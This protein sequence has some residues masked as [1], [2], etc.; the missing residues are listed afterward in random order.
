VGTES[1]YQIGERVSTVDGFPGEII[2]VVPGPVNGTESYHVLLD[3]NLGGGEYTPSQIKPITAQRSA[4]LQEFDTLGTA[5]VD[6]P[7]LGDILVKKPNP[8]KNIKMGSKLACLNCGCDDPTDDHGNPNN[9]TIDS[10]PSCGHRFNKK[11]SSIIALAE[12]RAEQLEQN[13]DQINRHQRPRAGAVC[14]HCKFWSANAIAGSICPLCGSIMQDDNDQ[15]DKDNVSKQVHDSSDF[16]EADDQDDDE[17]NDSLDFGNPSDSSDSDSGDSGGDSGTTASL[18][19]SLEYYTSSVNSPFGEVLVQVDTVNP[20]A[21]RAPDKNE[22]PASAGFASAPDSPGWGD[23]SKVVSDAEG[24]G[25]VYGSRYDEFLFEADLDS[26][27]TLREEPEA[28]LPRTDG[29][30][31]TLHEE[32]E[33]A[34]PSTDGN[35]VTRHTEPELAVLPQK[36]TDGKDVGRLMA[37]SNTTEEEDGKFSNISPDYESLQS[38]GSVEDIV[39]Q[40]QTTASHLDV[41]NAGPAVGDSDIAKAAKQYLAKTSMKMFSPAEQAAIINEGESVRTANFDRLDIVG[42]HYVDV[43][44]TLRQEE[45]SDTLWF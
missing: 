42:T 27:A 31:G 15:A 17:L 16:T 23:S 45:E 22:N 5:V 26:E 13:P 29:S 19:N 24:V 43:E 34:L 7:E 8:A 44:A 3:G 36:R 14:A 28:A 2:R 20:G 37:G 25:S 18:H 9:I 30:E 33:A 10:C 32:P 39:A 1:S 11:A 21:T 40:F 41:V 4:S 6:Y 35:Y 38:Q 12:S